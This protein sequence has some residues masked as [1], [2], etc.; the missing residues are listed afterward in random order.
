[1]RA[2]GIK[3]FIFAGGDAVAALQQAHDLAETA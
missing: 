2:A 3:E 1:L